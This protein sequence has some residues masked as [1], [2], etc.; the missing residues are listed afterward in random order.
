MA[1]LTD[2]TTTDPTRPRGQGPPRASTTAKAALVLSAL[3]LLV[4]GFVAVETL[5][6]D[7]FRRDVDARLACLEQPGVADCGVDGE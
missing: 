3:A 6:E 4:S 7:G 5:N 1:S 2:T